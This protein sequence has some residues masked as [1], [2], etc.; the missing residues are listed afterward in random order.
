MPRVHINLHDIDEIE[1]LEQQEDWD[2]L[3]GLSVGEDRRDQ[4]VGQETRSRNGDRGRG[5]ERRFGGSE[6]VAR[7]RADRR[8]TSVRVARRV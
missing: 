8:K 6:V 7:K 1:D 3:I 2:Q 5:G 4:R